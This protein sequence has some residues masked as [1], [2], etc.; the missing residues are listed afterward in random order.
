M[1]VLDNS[2]EPWNRWSVPSLDEHT[3]SVVPAI[4][5]VKK[6]NHSDAEEIQDTQDG[7]N[8]STE[9]IGEDSNAEQTEL[10]S[11]T[12]QNHSVTEDVEIE[13]SIEV[14]EDTQVQPFS[15]EELLEIRKSVELEAYQSGFEKGEKHGF[16]SG[17]KKAKEE[18]EPQL[19]EAVAEI[20]TLTQNISDASQELDQEIE[21]LMVNCIVKLA[22]SVIRRELTS[23]Q[24]DIVNLVRESLLALPVSQ[25]SAEV[26]LN[27]K[28][29]ELLNRYENT[30]DCSLVADDSVT[31]G[32]CRVKSLESLVEFNLEERIESAM[33][34]FRQAGLSVARDDKNES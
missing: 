10:D 9:I 25:E 6:R 31:Q 8:K 18:I 32:S 21:Q 7:N 23:S 24:D 16:E 22:E 19:L 1:C 11:G 34:Q 3:D 15:A 20:K 12:E 33:S 17:E 13:E 2:D 29:L 26:A 14:V 5:R 27:S 30:F 4:R 28:D